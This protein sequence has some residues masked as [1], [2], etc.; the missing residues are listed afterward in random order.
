MKTALND[1]ARE[2]ARPGLVRGGILS[3]EPPIID[4]VSAMDYLA[5]PEELFTG[6]KGIDDQHYE[7]F[8]RANK[9]LFPDTDQLGANDIFDSLAFLIKYVNKHFYDE[10]RLMEFYKY[11]RLENHQKQHERLRK[12]VD[13]LYR[14]GRNDASV[15]GLASSL[16]YLF[17]DWYIY[18]IKEWD[19]DYAR[20]L[21]KHIKLELI[22][23][24]SQ[25]Q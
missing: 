21:Q 24:G 3:G 9:V 14:K 7:L 10:E 5:L 20:F 8:Y 13:D 25:D 12:E 16:H 23:I 15:Q 2:T 6:I 19:L 18:H 1:I 17:S 22:S 4:E 11:E